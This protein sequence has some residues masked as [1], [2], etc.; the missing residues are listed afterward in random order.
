MQHAVIYEWKG[1]VMIS[2]ATAG[3][4]VLLQDEVVEDYLPAVNALIG[5]GFKP[6]H[7]TMESISMCCR[8]FGLPGSYILGI[9]TRD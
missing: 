1:R 6:L 9:F 3:L 7:L 4:V 8:I 2:R 5:D